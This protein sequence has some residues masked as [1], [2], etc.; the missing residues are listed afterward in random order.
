MVGIEDILIRIRGKDQT[1]GAFKSIEGNASKMGSA[2]TSAVGMMG[3]M[4]GYDMVNSLM[5]AGRESINASMQ[6][7]YFAGRL[8]MSE[9]Q[10]A[11]FRKELDSM[12]QDFKKV[13]MTSVGATAADLAARYQLPQEK[14]SDLTK[15]TAVMSS[16]FIRNGRTQEDSV[17]AVADA[18]DGQFKRL[19]EIGITQDTL[20]KNGW[21]GNLEDQASLIDALNK[22]ME[23]M[24]YDKIAQDITNLD[25]AYAALTVAGGHLIESVLI[26]MMPAILGVVDAVTN[27]LYFLKDNSWASAALAITGLGLAFLYVAGT[28]AA[29]EVPM[30]ALVASA[31]P[32]FISSIGTAVT[33]LMSLASGQAAVTAEEVMGAA[34][35]ASNGVA[36]SAEGLAALEASGGFW[37]MAAAELASLWPILLIIAAVAAFIVAVEQI[38]EAL[39]WWTDFSTMIDAIRA[40]ITRLWEAFINSPQVQG[41]LQGIQAAFQA[42]WGALQP[43]F[44]W[45]TDAWNNLFKSEGPGSGGPDIVHL[46]IVKFTELGDIASQTFTVIKT[47]FEIIYSIVQPVASAIGSLLGVFFSLIGGQI[48]LQQAFTTVSNI[49]NGLVIRLRAVLTSLAMTL[50]PV[51]M[52][53]LSQ[54]PGI[55]WGHLIRIPELFGEVFS[56]VG[57]I[58]LNALLGIPPAIAGF[59]SNLLSSVRG[60][61]VNGVAGATAEV[62]SSIL[63]SISPVLQILVDLFQITWINIH[64]LI[65]GVVGPIVDTVSGLIGIF[66]Q[67]ASGQISLTG[68]LSSAWELIGTNILDIILNITESISDF[69]LS[70]LEIGAEAAENFL[71]SFFPQFSGIPTKIAG[72][73]RQGIIFISESFLDWVFA[74]GESAISFGL[75]FINGI[76]NLPDEVANIVGQL[77]DSFFTVNPALQ[78]VQEVFDVTWTN[79]SSLI[80]GVLGPVTDTITGLIDIFNQLTSGQISLVDAV[81]SA[82]QLYGTNI[83]E[84]FMNIGTIFTDFALSL[85]EI[86]AEAAENFVSAFFPQFS[87]IPTQIAGFLRQGI[88]SISDAVLDYVY[89]AGTAS[90]QFGT[91]IINGIGDIEGLIFSTVTGAFSNMYNII[92][93]YAGNIGSAARKLGTS[94]YNG[95]VNGVK[96]IGGG[97]SSALSGIGARVS[98]IGGGIVGRARSIGNGIGSAIHNGIRNAP[99]RVTQILRNIIVRLVGLR[100]AIVARARS[101]ATGLRNGILNR[102]NSIPGRVGSIIGSIPGRIAS[103]AG[104]V[105]GAAASLASQA[106]NAVVSGFSGLANK[107]YQEFVNIGNKIRESISSAVS[108]ATQFGSDIVNAVLGALH[109]ASPGIIQRKIAIE[110]ADI[111]GRIKES[112][113]SVTRSAKDYAK[114][115]I[116]GFGNPSVAGNLDLNPNIN[117]GLPLM[118][119]L[120]NNPFIN[121]NAITPASVSGL[122]SSNTYTPTTNKGGNVTIIVS[123]GAVQLDA[124]NLT[125]SESKKVLINALEGLDMISNIDIRGDYGY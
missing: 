115:I 84:I 52:N 3:G 109:I 102:I 125:T 64:S 92:T 110:F 46:I 12:Q 13:N 40:G 76:S 19:Q 14:L 123:E 16:E 37:A 49:I 77:I 28:A 7:D 23:G 8:N 117:G 39:G 96:G 21:N 80:G 71:A 20:K 98:S 89:A 74:A 56:Q 61:I 68:A 63:S 116:D 81:S 70:L 35:H 97:V 38:G 73:L 25:D 72:F 100:G 79:I 83:V 95:V 120:V 43:V 32:G 86:G 53:A 118:Q 113:G 34:A 9:Q 29:M 36:V 5:N 4:I 45:L 94:I 48:S 22:S 87:G 88:I 107:V 78:T 104:A 69:A 93:S 1:A 111:P 90:T 11:D 62:G 58:V 6:L 124:R 112:I 30:M 54:V 27:V 114:G 121:N 44:S 42:L 10:T 33:G 105:A 122:A 31:M 99:A 2:L 103:A 57:P 60:R 59:V 108:A 82:W 47:G 55:I 18:L 24:G 50:G 65:K 26:P 106:V 66:G 119:G 51:I 91:Y 75:A 67:L 101:I 15:M 41:V 17:L 85:L